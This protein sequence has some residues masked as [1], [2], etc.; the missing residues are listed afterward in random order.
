[1]LC[2]VCVL[3]CVLC[4]VVC[5]CVCVVWGS[6][7]SMKYVLIYLSVLVTLECHVDTELNP[8]RRNAFRVPVSCL[9]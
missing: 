3:C 5:V 6:S 9:K 4:C 7:N 8:S 2:C 1:M